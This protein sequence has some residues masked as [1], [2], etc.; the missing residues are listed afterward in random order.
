MNTTQF[1]PF[2]KPSIGEEEIHEVEDTLRSGWLTTGPRTSRF[3][4]EFKQYVHADHALA[5]NSATAGLHLALVAL[6]I[7]AGDEVITTPITF[8]STVHTILHTGARPVL[9]D[10]GADGNIDPDSIRE[11]ITDRTKAIV[12][13]HLAGLPCNMT[14]IWDIARKHGLHVIE[15][16]AH[17]VGSHYRGRPI[18]AS[19]VAGMGGSDAVVFSFYAT[20]NLTTAEGGMVATANKDLAERMRSLCLHGTNRDAWS[21]Y[22]RT[23]S[24][25]YEV[26]DGGFKYNLSD[27]QS[28]VGI[29]QLRKLEQFIATRKRYAEIYKEAFTGLE[30]LEIPPD[31]GTSRHAWHLYIIRLNLNRLNLDRSE[32]IESLREQG[33]G[34]SVHFIPIPLHPYF[35]PL[36]VGKESSWPRAF[37]LYPRIISLP[38]YPAMTEEQVRYVAAAV[39]QIAQ[40]ARQLRQSA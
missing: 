1:I 5:V 11:C 35:A 18:G 31:D 33:I 34:T 21:R 8:C 24:W 3:E 22:A 25:Y 26:V 15:D 39:R 29:P 40:A 38:L 9:A 23:G 14:A 4:T 19:D 37:D 30:E 32:F 20:K 17:A 13:V 6:G 28:A 12:P 27:L 2:H 16:A 10:I 36:F 7:H